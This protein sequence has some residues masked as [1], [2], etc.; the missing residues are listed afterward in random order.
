MGD[1]RLLELVQIYFIELGYEQAVVKKY[2]SVQKIS[3]MVA[4]RLANASVV[5]MES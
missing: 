3:E 4:I 5:R 2:F 1:I